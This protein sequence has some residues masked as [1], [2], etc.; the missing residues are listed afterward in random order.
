MD[1][2]N[3]SEAELHLWSRGLVHDGRQRRRSHVAQWW[4][5]IA[6]YAGDFWTE[7]D[8][9]S[10]I[11]REPVKSADHKV[12]LP[13]NLA[14][15]AVRTEYAKLLKNRPI[16]NAL[17]R[18]E[19]IEDLDAAEVGTGML[20]YYGEQRF[21]KAKVRRRMLMWTLIA[22][23]GG[24]FVDWNPKALGEIEVFVDPATGDPVFN[25]ELIAQYTEYAKTTG[26]RKPKTTTIPQGDLEIKH[27]SPFALIFDF[28]KL[29]VEES[30]WCIVS[31][32]W[33]VD[34]AFV[35]WGVE[36]EPQREALPDIM[37]RRMLARADLSSRLIL[38]TPKAQNMAEVHRL[39]IKPGH[40]Y[41]QQGAEIV[42]TDDTFI[43]SNEFPHYHGELPVAAMGHIPNPISQHPMSILQ[44]LKPVVLE[45]SKT[46]SQMVENRNLMSNPPWIEFR[47]NRIVGEIQNKPG[48]RLKVDFVPGI[49]E[50][51]PVQMPD[52]PAYV[53][54]LPELFGQHVL[55]I[56][57]Q[58]ETSQGQVP[59]GARSGVAIA[60]LTEENDTKLGPTV[61]EYEE[62]IERASWLELM[63]YVQYYT[64]ERTV[65]LYKSGSK[66]DVIHFKGEMLSGI[67]GVQ[68]Q[69]GSA[70]PKSLAAKQ[71]YTLDLYDRG[72]IRNP[73]EVMEMLDLGKGEQDEWEKDM[74]QADRENFDMENGK[75][76]QVLEWYNHAAH[77]YVHH[78]QMKSQSFEDLDS[79]IQQIFMDHEEDHQNF[80][81][82]QQQ[83]QTAQ[84]N[85]QQ[86]R[87][88]G[89]TQAS[90]GQNQG[91]PQ[92]AYSSPDD[93]GAVAAGGSAGAPGQ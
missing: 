4:E 70:L 6:T 37:E 35:R 53:K 49:P 19:D 34:A 13:I 89:P 54:D 24:I 42:F 10:N 84:A 33:D 11:L 85:L 5:N 23:Y 57:G 3:T 93:I 83:Q 16:V 47:Q 26:H 29:Y 71:Q 20:N 65:R 74:D 36:L 92:G 50:P 39:F 18:S 91:G 88:T 67:P 81:R 60:Y 32:V 55:E 79:E 48:M 2:P 44:A 38:D 45:I 40:R 21:H 62:V 51:H 76:R 73:R 28:S 43:V 52:L 61:Q 75:Q 22:G 9:H 78:S 15:P 64:T 8:I 77:L 69:A 66:P 1:D 86:G 25:P 12:K 7:F 68:V 46:E 72:L 59:P 41:F 63:C 31:E 58:N 87:G 90:N 27:L 17:S 80:I 56:S 82:T 14:Q 30:A